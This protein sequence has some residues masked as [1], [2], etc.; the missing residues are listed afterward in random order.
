M[1]GVVLGIATAT[2]F[3]LQPLLTTLVDKTN[4]NT[5]SI[6]LLIGALGA[7]CAGGAALT[8]GGSVLLFG[9]ACVCLQAAPAFSNAMGMQAIRAGYSLNFAVARACGSVSF[10]V[11]A[12]L[13]AVLIS[14]FGNQAIAA[15]ASVSALLFC[16]TTLLF[17]SV[18]VTGEAEKPTPIRDFFRENPRFLFVLIASVLM[19][20]GHNAL[21]N[22]MYRVVESK[23]PAGVEETAVTNLQGT[24]LMLVAFL[25]LPT[26]F[27]FRTLVKKIRCDVW[28]GVSCLCMT[29]RLLLTWL[30]PGEMGIILA[31]LTQMGGYAIYAVA[32]VYYV[33]SVISKKNVVKGQTYLGASNTLG[34]LIAYF[35]GGNLTELFGVESMLLTSLATAVAGTLIMFLSMQRVE[36]TAGVDE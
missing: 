30:L 25:E 3:L 31:Q 23:L 17:P 8:A 28:L 19:Y 26:M 36:K 24:V 12:K 32:S 20:I 13:T 4:L 5:R 16:A 7:L 9:A 10:G 6:S 14:A 34:C 1:A 35:V 21:S 33:G 18:Q 15:A 27:L 11:A 29:L 22:A 2:A